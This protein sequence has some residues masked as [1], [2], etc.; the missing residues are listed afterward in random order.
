ME[1]KLKKNGRKGKKN[2]TNKYP[3]NKE[4]RCLEEM[5]VKES[6]KKPYFELDGYSP[7]LSWKYVE[8]FLKS[9]TGKPLDDV[10]SEFTQLC[11]KTKVFNIKEIFDSHIVKDEGDLN[12]FGG[13]YVVDGILKYKSSNWMKNYRDK[14][15]KIADEYKRHVEWN[16][17]HLPSVE[18]IKE[19]CKKTSMYERPVFLGKFYCYTD[20]KYELKS[21]YL[22]RYYPFEYCK[23]ILGLNYGFKIKDDGTLEIINN[24]SIDWKQEEKQFWFVL[25]RGKS[26]Y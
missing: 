1:L 9:R 26:W 22:S 23:E 11:K 18:K 12:K 19:I 21:V 13:C 24:T 10:F 3:R 16:E 25:K 6:M 7:Y 15:K 20:K 17:S 14:E 2:R 5:P 8:K 4:K